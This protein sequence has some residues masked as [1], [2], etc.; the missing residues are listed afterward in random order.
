M[1]GVSSDD[2]KLWLNGL[3]LILQLG[4]VNVTRVRKGRIETEMARGRGWGCGLS[5]PSVQWNLGHNI[6]NQTIF[7][8]VVNILTA[9]L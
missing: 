6:N 3:Q 9:S 2:Y 8:A 5:A 7:N 4:S 1:V